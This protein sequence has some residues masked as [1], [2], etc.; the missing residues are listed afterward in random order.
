MKEQ[1]R[2]QDILESLAEYHEEAFPIYREMRDLV[3]GENSHAALVA[4]S[5][6][7]AT[8]LARVSHSRETAN[9]VTEALSISVRGSLS[10]MEK[11]NLCIWQ[12]GIQ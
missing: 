9:L 8:I 6:S 3:E 5:M 2:V 1:E 12:E 10:E 11:E 7:I 4:I